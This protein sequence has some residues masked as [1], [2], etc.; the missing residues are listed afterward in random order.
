MKEHHKK[1]FQ[2]QPIMRKVLLSL[3]PILIGS[4][5]FFGW[6]TLVLLAV[7][8]F[9]GVLTEQLFE[10]R[11]NKKVTE[12]VFVTCYLFTLTLPA[13]TPLWAAAIGIIFGVAFAKGVF[14]GFGFNIFNPA[15][16]ARTFVYVTFPEPL[17]ISWNTVASGFPGGFAK[18][19]T[20]AVDSISQSSPLIHFNQTGQMLPL[21]QLILGNSAG[22]L[23]E[24]SAV[25]ILIAAIYLLYTKTADWRLILSPIVGFLTLNTILF[26]SN[27]PN[28]PNPIFS[29]FS[30]GFLFLSVFMATDPI[31]APRT[32][33]GKWVYGI[34][35]GVVT[36]IIRFFGMFAEGAMFAVLIMNTFVPIIDD[37]VKYLKAAKKK[38]VAA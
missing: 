34:L 11:H 27:V 4:I 5:Y 12:A 3:M 30:G 10:K 8:T 2:K 29:L 20:P 28:I 33:E 1:I 38:E 19:I 21:K 35:I 16:A 7:V 36:I 37:S 23:G 26:F 22:S 6:R 13:S 25:L 15:L 31:T 17:T 24:T 32:K 14:G 18:Y 9:F